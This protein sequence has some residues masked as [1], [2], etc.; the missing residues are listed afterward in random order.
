M[1]IPEIMTELGR[2]RSEAE[3][4]YEDYRI[5][6]M[7]L[8][9]LKTQLTEELKAI[10]LKS[11]KSEKYTASIVQKPTIIVTHEESV[12]DW[13]E[14]N[15]DIEPDLY[16]GLKKSSFDPLAKNW[17]SKTGEVIPGTETQ[18]S[19]YLSIKQNKENKK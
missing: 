5:K 9:S 10:G 3:S 6:K 18:V 15:P 11:A 1:T 19:E 8:D 2:L 16:I 4:A 7:E 14:N 17:F 12:I 13:L